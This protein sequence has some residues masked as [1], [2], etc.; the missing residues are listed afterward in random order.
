MTLLS[1]NILHIGVIVIVV[2]SHP[3]SCLPTRAGASTPARRCRLRSTPCAR[4]LPSDRAAPR[5]LVPPPPDQGKHRGVVEGGGLSRV[6]FYVLKSVKSRLHGC[7]ERWAM[8]L[9]SGA[10]RT[11]LQDYG[12]PGTDSREQS[13]TQHDTPHLWYIRHGQL[14]EPS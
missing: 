4:T 12:E 2:L 7:C 13:R 3:R 14:F 5:L 11:R 6:N 9:T 8:C 10:E 1:K